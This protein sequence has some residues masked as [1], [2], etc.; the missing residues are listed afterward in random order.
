LELIQRPNHQSLTVEKTI[1][2]KKRTSHQ[3]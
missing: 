1:S 2:D 3:P